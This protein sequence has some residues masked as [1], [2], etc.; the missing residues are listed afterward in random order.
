MTIASGKKADYLVV[1]VF[2]TQAECDI[3]YNTYQERI[4]KSVGILSKGVELSDI[5]IDDLLKTPS[6]PN[7]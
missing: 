1:G 6:E 3:Y 5:T 4:R 2:A 7:S